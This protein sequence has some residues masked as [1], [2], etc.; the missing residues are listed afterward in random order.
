M[1]VSILFLKKTISLSRTEKHAMEYIGYA[2]QLI[3]A[4]GIFNVW[5]LRYGRST[6]YRGGDAS[7]LKE[8]FAVYGLP[9]WSFFVVG[10][11]KLLAATLLIA[12]IA[13]PE[14][15]MPAATT[16]ILLM[17]GAFAMHLKVKDPFHKAL[18][19]LSLLV[20]SV[21]AILF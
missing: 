12:G 1:D 21:L 10:F 4:L 7:N 3:I 2:S 20:L 6:H 11:F 16:M 14:L 9:E 5:I 17:I 18:P 15:V 19:A 13:Y 8:E